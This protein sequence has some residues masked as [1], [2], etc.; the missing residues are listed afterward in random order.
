MRKLEFVLAQEEL[1]REPTHTPLVTEF[2]HAVVL[3]LC[4]L[5]PGMKAGL[6][7]F[8][9][10]LADLDETAARS[11]NIGDQGEYHRNHE[12]GNQDGEPEPP[13]HGESDGK[14]REK[15]DRSE[16]HPDSSR[17]MVFEGLA[18]LGVQVYGVIES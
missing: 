18:A 1:Y 5:R 4:R 6:Q 16:H 2:G 9:T 10:S 11:I 13:W 3:F 17:D 14:A 8:H 12:W 15:R 7:S